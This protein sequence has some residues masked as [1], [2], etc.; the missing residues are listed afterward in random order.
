M[1]MNCAITRLP[2]RWHLLPGKLGSSRNR[3]ENLDL[4]EAGRARW[5]RRCIG[6]PARVLEQLRHH[7]A[8]PRP[9]SSDVRCRDRDGRD[10]VSDRCNAGSALAPGRARRSFGG[11]PSAGTA[12]RG[13]RHWHRAKPGD[14]SLVPSPPAILAWREGRRRPNWEPRGPRHGV[15]PTNVIRIARPDHPWRAAPRPRFGGAP[16]LRGLR[17]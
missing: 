4:G 5:N 8:R 9:G 17:R 7:H 2:L 15:Q 10:L 14:P 3:H 6:E 1:Q 16:E 13:N 12:G 11:D